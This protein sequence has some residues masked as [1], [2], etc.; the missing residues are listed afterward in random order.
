MAALKSRR[1]LITFVVIFIALACVPVVAAT[2]GKPFYITVFNRIMILAIA[3]VSLD[4]LLGYGGMVS[5]GHAAYVGVGAYTV[6]IM[7]Y[8]VDNG[9]A[10]LGLVPGSY[11]AFIVWPSAIIIGALVALVIGAISLRAEGFYFIMITLAF[12]QMVYY[13]FVSWQAYGGDDGLQ[14]Q[15]MDWPTAAMSAT[16]FYYLIWGSLLLVT[17]LVG[18]I[19]ASRFGMV[20]RGCRQNERRMRAIGL[21]TYRYRLGAFVIAGAIAAYAGVLMANNETFIS[22]P[23]MSWPQSAELLIMV[24]L[25][26]S[27]TV[28][29]AIVGAAAYA[30]L[31]LVLGNFTIHWQIIFGPFFILVVLFARRGLLQLVFGTSRER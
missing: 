6:A 31:E 4:L 9:G 23:A 27:G 7:A 30:L 20:L 28:Y 16:Q 2:F 8:H 3:A 19:V 12:A 1:G 29:G 10:F 15:N 13:F 25:G 5:L 17:L 18:R 22:P 26:G 21:P 24:V 11:N 14:M